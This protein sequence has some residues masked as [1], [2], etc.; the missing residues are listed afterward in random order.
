MNV[1]ESFYPRVHERG[2]SLGERRLV[3]EYRIRQVG[4]AWGCTSRMVWR[5]PA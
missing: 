5:G 1:I 4:L 2:W 3:E